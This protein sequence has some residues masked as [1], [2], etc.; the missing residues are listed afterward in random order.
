[1][2]ESD[3]LEISDRE[4]PF[5]S[6]PSDEEHLWDAIEIL[7]ER[8]G[9]YLVKWAGV[10]EHGKPWA[11]SWTNKRDCTDDMVEEWKRKKALKKMEKQKRKANK[12]SKARNSTV[13]SSKASSSRQAA[14]AGP[15]TRCLRS[16]TAVPDDQHNAPEKEYE[17]ISRTPM[18]RR[19]SLDL[20]HDSDTSP[21]AAPRP[22]KKRR[23]LPEPHQNGINGKGSKPKTGPSEASRHSSRKP[24]VPPS[25]DEVESIVRPN[26]KGKSAERSP[27]PPPKI[28]TLLHRAVAN[29]RNNN[30]LD[31]PPRSPSGYFDRTNSLSKSTVLSPRAQARL[32]QFD[33]D[34]AAPTQESSEN[35]PLF[36]PASSEEPDSIPLHPRSRSP[37]RSD[38]RRSISRTPP[39]PHP[40]VQR[41]LSPDIAVSGY[42]RASPASRPTNSR[43]PSA[44]R[45]ADDSY[46]V[47]DVPETQSTPEESPSPPA[48]PKKATLKSQMKSRSK[49]SGSIPPPILPGTSAMKPLALFGPLPQIT[50]SMFNAHALGEDEEE[51]DDLMS[52][53][54]QFSSPEKGAGPRKKG[55]R[56]TLDVKG[57]GR[58][59]PVIVDDEYEEDDLHRRVAARGAELAEAARAQRRA[60]LA[61]YAD[62]WKAK[63]TTLEEIREQTQQPPIN[64]VGVGV[65]MISTES[66]GPTQSTGKSLGHARYTGDV[67]QLRQE[68]EENTQDVMAFYQSDQDHGDVANGPGSDLNLDHTANGDVDRSEVGGSVRSVGD[69]SEDLTTEV[70][71]IDIPEKA[72]WNRERASQQNLAVEDLG[73]S[74]QD[75]DDSMEDNLVRLFW[76][77][78]FES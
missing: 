39:S 57:K 74:Q 78:P 58:A 26:G 47:G 28:N 71:D 46:R 12:I 30:G 64:G 21:P 8:R 50:S 24:T 43:H 38:P 76:S 77:L 55:Q 66:D 33:R 51:V 49:S 61:E 18:K 10:D 9:Q 54:E 65:S 23:V 37:S 4:I 5:E 67:K 13:S 3:V 44:R 45:T 27:V 70:D 60:E 6:H 41:G 36:F 22:A 20:V 52:S 31:T 35:I 11:D 63:R 56:R 75:Q 73:I 69:R 72:A 34:L 2:S 19:L 17:S 40:S 14:S 25:D 32:S 15:S 42:V 1:M 62:R 7:N 68:E 16:R 53:I 59:L 29:P 48:S